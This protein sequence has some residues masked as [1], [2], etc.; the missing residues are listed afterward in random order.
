MFG[1]GEFSWG[2]TSKTGMHWGTF[3]DYVVMDM[4]LCRSGQVVLQVIL[5]YLQ[6]LL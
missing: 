4:V 5:K 6:E 1:V 2:Q 3:D